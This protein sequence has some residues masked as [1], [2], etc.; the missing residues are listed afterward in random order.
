[1]RGPMSARVVVAVWLTGS[2]VLAPWT[3]HGQ[4]VERTVYASVLN[5][6]GTPV[7]DLSVRDVIVRENDLAREVLRVSPATDPFRIAVLVDS[8]QAAEP[9]IH[10]FREAVGAFVAAMGD[11]HEMALVSFGERPTVL[12]DY[13]RDRAKLIE[14]TGRLFAQR[15]SGAYLMDAIVEVSRGMRKREG[16]RRT[17]VVLSTQGPEFSNRYHQY[18]IDELRNAGAALHVLSIGVP[19]DLGNDEA[20][21][22]RLALDQGSLQTGGRQ[23]D[24]LTSSTLPAT[25]RA[26]AAELKGQYQIVYAR[27]AAL[28]PPESIRVEARRPD[29]I[30]RAARLL[31]KP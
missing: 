8:S 22:L 30:V 31:P 7:A 2:V 4:S 17:L 27:P 5:K 18:V 12:A 11:G 16:G 23:Q 29:L 26:L 28:I 6:D 1:M 20:R 21:E 14:G 15:A 25:M 3:V 9:Y 13:T 10:D 19:P 24:L